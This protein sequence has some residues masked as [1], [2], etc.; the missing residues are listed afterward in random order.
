[1]KSI[2]DKIMELEAKINKLQAEKEALL[3]ETPTSIGGRIRKTALLK[4]VSVTEM[5][6]F[7]DITSQT[8]HHYLNDER[9][10]SALA[11]GTLAI[12]FETSCDYLIFGEEADDENNN[13][14]L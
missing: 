14:F 6:R 5:A 10:I 7:L 4:G 13:R 9:K 12:L 3:T 8:M 11:L 1:M 2:S